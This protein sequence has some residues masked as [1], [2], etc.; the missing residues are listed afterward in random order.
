MKKLLLLF[1]LLTGLSLGA[2]T[3][4]IGINGGITTIASYDGFPPFGSGSP[5]YPQVG[6][7]G[8]I[9]YT[10]ILD[11]NFTIKIQQ[12]L[13]I[14]NFLDD[15]RNRPIQ[16]VGPNTYASNQYYT[17]NI[18]GGYLIQISNRHSTAFEAGGSLFY[19]FRNVGYTVGMPET[20]R[21]YRGTW[22]P[23]DRHYGIYLAINHNYRIYRSQQYALYLT[24]SLRA[25]NLFNYLNLK[26]SLSNESSSRILPELTFGVAV[27]FGKN[28]RKRF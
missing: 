1:I 11:N 25:T 26:E 5:F 2:Q 8:N 22:N 12:G 13:T 3:H 9:V 6:Y 16:L 23:R 20:R 10:C 27:A 15:G 18:G 28:G 17:A 7:V 19:M 21:V 4:R 24:G 14:L